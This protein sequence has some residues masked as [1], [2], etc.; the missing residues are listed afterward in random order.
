MRDTDVQNLLRSNEAQNMGFA[1]GR[2][3]IGGRDFLE[4]STH[5]SEACIPHRIQFLE[6]PA[7]VGRR[8]GAHYD[9]RADIIRVP[10]LRVLDDPWGR[11]TVIH[12]CTHALLDLRLLST[13]ERTGE[14][15]ALIAQAWYYLNCG[16]RDI[17]NGVAWGRIVAIAEALRSQFLTNNRSEVE[18]N[19]DQINNVRLSARDFGYSND[20]YPAHGI[21][22]GLCR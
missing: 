16:L 11:G 9:P 18:L 10:S 12:E 3:H 21:R 8:W 6:R 7:V 2:I 22:V 20:T 19:A 15:M 17:A 14:A 1:F 4:L 5:F 13:S